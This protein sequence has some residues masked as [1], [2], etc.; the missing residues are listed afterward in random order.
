MMIVAPAAT[1]PATN[2][3]G[4][5]PFTLESFTPDAVFKV[6]KNP[7]YHDA[8]NVKA[9][10]VEFVRVPANDPTVSVNALLAHQADAADPLNQTSAA[11]GGGNGDFEIVTSL[12]TNSVLGMGVVQVPVPAHDVRVRRALAAPQQGGHQQ[13]GVPGRGRS[14]VGHVRGGQ[15]VLRSQ[16]GRGQRLRPG[17]GVVA[18]TEAGYPDGF[19]SGVL[20]NGRRSAACGRGGAAAV[21]RHRGRGQPGGADQPAHRLL[22]AG[23]QPDP[24][25]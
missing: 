17:R 18:A 10:G 22:P 25:C 7:R 20:P 11:A 19:R 23:P 16:P 24:V 14:V 3:I 12:D 2:P 21:G 1:A 15:P 6:K 4:A 9:A 13:H 8:A 5:G